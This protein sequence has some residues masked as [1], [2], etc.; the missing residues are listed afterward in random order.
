MI[1]KIKKILGMNYI[2]FNKEVNG[3]Y[4]KIRK[5]NS[6]EWE[7]RNTTYGE[8]EWKELFSWIYEHISPE[9]VFIEELILWNL[10]KEYEL[11]LTYKFK[12]IKRKKEKT[13]KLFNDL[14]LKLTKELKK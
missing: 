4:T 5:Y 3:F 12:Q 8:H 1:T 13:K 10:P 11:E 7:L 6:G 14:K 2:I 9:E